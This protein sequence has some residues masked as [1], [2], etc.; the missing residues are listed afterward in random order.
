MKN[1]YGKTLDELKNIA[2]GF[3]EPEYRGEQLFNW[4][5]KK[6][7]SCIEEMSSL[8]ADLI[9]S[10]K[11]EYRI[12]FPE[13]FESE[14][15][16]DGTVKYLMKLRDGSHIESVFLPREDYVSFCI[17]T[18]VGC[19]VGCT[20]CKTS[21]MGFVRNLK[22]GEILGQIRNILLEIEET[23]SINILLMGMGEPLYN[24]ENVMKSVR[25]MNRGFNISHQRITLSTAGVIPGIVRLREEEVRPNLSVSLNA[26]DEETRTDLMPVNEKFPLEALINAL[27]DYPLKSGEILTLEYVLISGIN[28]SK[29]DILRLSEI[30]DRTGAKVNLIP[31][32]PNKDSE[33]QPPSEERICE[34]KEKLKDAGVVVTIRES[35]GEDINAACGQL[36]SEHSG[37]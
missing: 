18:Q 19:S 27:E 23:E 28:D 7:A 11:D 32:N 13:I 31:L 16:S 20:F 26:A 25:L 10:I 37:V 3:D 17:S 30:A 29:N 4:L 14:K 5:Y 6:H 21:A 22:C 35:R 9:S 2:A 8:P 15:S 33:H 12:S 24:Y 1:L 36:Y 34:F